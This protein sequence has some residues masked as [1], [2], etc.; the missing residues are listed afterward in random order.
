MIA[1]PYFPPPGTEVCCLYR[2]ANNDDEEPM[3]GVILYLDDPRAWIA[4]VAFYKS[5][6]LQL[7]EA[8]KVTAHVTHCLVEGLLMDTVPVLYQRD[9]ASF[10]HFDRHLQVYAEYVPGWLEERR[11]QIEN[12]KKNG[13]R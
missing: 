13:T 3:R 8:A 10:I 6:P 11:L 5:T 12:R 7:P 4:T 9:G 1:S 2:L